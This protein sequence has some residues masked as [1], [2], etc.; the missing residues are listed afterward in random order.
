M[1]LSRSG[2]VADELDGGSNE[3]VLQVNV[4]NIVSD[5]CVSEKRERRASFEYIHNASLK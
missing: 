1:P 3:Q 5:H 4:C 2:A